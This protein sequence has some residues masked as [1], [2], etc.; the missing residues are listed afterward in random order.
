MREGGLLGWSTNALV[1][2]D[3]EVPGIL[4]RV[5]TAAPA[6]RQAIFAA[7]AAHEV[8]AGVF[9]AG[10][11]LFPQS[12]AEVVRHGRAADILRLTFGD[13]PEVSIGV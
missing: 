10:E 3:D 9:D 13:L 4:S 5:L 12:F 8:K 1:K 11:D 7:L 2:L 6:R